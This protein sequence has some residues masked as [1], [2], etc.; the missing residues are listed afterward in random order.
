MVTRVTPFAGGVV[1]T[2]PS[3]PDPFSVSDP[4][5]PVHAPPPGTDSSEIPLP[6]PCA[7]TM[8]GPRGA[9]FTN[10]PDDEGFIPAP[11]AHV[12][13]GS[14]DE[15]DSPPGQ[16]RNSNMSSAS[17]PP[18][19]DNSPGG[20]RSRHTA[21]V[22]KDSSIKNTMTF[23]KRKQDMF[24]H[25][26]RVV[27]ENRWFVAL[28]TI[29]TVYA[30]VG[31]DFRLAATQKP[32]DDVFNAITLFCFFVF[33]AEII[34][35]CYGKCDY[36]WSFFF[37]LD[38][39]STLTLILDLTYVAETLL[40]D[41]EDVGMDLRSGR[42]ARVGAKAGRIVRVIRLVRII[43]L[44][45][46]IQDAKMERQRRA[47]G[48][49]EEDDWG[50]DD[51]NKSARLD[52]TTIGESRVGRKLSEMTT[53][54]VVL[55]VL[56]MLLVLPF[57]QT[58]ASNQP[59]GSPWFAA[60]NVFDAYREWSANTS[61][62]EAER[63]HLVYERAILKYLY[64][65]NWFSGNL[66][67]WVPSE[68]MSA[69]SFQSHL[70]W[71]GIM[72]SNQE[73]LTNWAPD[74]SLRSSTVEAFQKDMLGKTPGSAIYNQGAM[75]DEVLPLISSQWRLG[76]PTKSGQYRLGF[77]ILSQALDGAAELTYTVPCPDTL[78]FSEKAKYYPRSTTVDEF[79]KWH[80][81]F[82]FDTRPYSRQEAYYALSVTS[83]I[84]VVLCAASLQFS[85]D[86]N[87]LVLRPVEN[88]VKRVEMIRNDP[89]IAVKMAD[90]EFKIEEKEKARLNKAT[91]SKRMQ[92]SCTQAFACS[93]K[94]VAE[95]M[96]TVI[97]EKTIIKLGSLLALGFGEAG[98]NIIGHNLE[99][100][101]SAGVNAMIQGMRVEAI[102]GSARIR[103]FS[104]ATEV[105]KAKVMT[106]VNQIAEIVHG[107]VSEF[108][109]AANKN[110]GDTFLLIWRISGLEDAM[111][112]RMADMSTIAF[113]R[114]LGEIHQ[115]PIL[116]AYRG[117]PALQQRLGGT[118]RVCVT[119]GLHAGWAIEGAVGSEF[120]I[121]ASYLSPNVS[122][123]VQVEQ[124][125]GI[126]TVPI[127][128]T[129]QVLRLCCP[130][131]AAKFRQIDLVVIRGSAEPTCLY[132]LDLDY[133]CLK[134]DT[135]FS[136]RP[137]TWNSRLRFKARQF[138][139]AE[140]SRKLDLEVRTVTM[141]EQCKEISHMRRRYSTEFL[142]L[143]NMGFQNYME[144]EWPVAGRLLTQT[145]SMLKGEEDGPS[146]ALLRFMEQSNF[147]A[148]SGWAGIHELSVSS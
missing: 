127:L 120:K 83:F 17:H 146:S 101:D 70:F 29:L 71:V 126:Y 138:L 78:R 144:G 60:D 103:D 61:A 132:C 21:F 107:V 102:I 51:M 33:G 35:S 52:Q 64:Y 26:C 92:T 129:E 105:L 44:W 15:Q 85:H 73:M 124:A 37:W 115:S 53:R 117:H 39:V 8:T 14:D 48:K 41:G 18:E 86:A 118:C 25:L 89:L 57:L 104:T 9:R 121:D 106:F 10:T 113:A 42:T 40:G 23:S 36:F 98:A 3:S 34:M 148:P 140:K 133:M 47:A 122:I 20:A 38:V 76:C 91:R 108:H 59:P 65:H 68:D 97:L 94:S 143:F 80:F 54:R 95:P 116:A 7:P 5:V 66:P 19:K 24:R 27:V 32:A 56:T 2:A 4:H 69:R 112:Q 125:T 134:V 13:T 16:R 100:S 114:I 50:E 96:E 30:L 46:A 135:D 74:P 131:I 109:G 111:V 6:R 55:L 58:D 43:K 72:S 137:A 147:N 62:P 141:F 87:R 45:K 139:E 110:N 31:D 49:N 145:Q 142:Q 79:K 28:T 81:A 63:A 123:A 99:S 67:D 84:C 1:P 93:S 130:E 82:Y 12:L 75:P 88:M 128:I 77:S 119:L 90:E 22:K 11:L 136:S